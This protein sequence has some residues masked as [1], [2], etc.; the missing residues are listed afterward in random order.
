V[1]GLLYAPGDGAALAAAVD[2][3][4]SDRALRERLR[5]A[6]VR[7]VQERSWQAVNEQLIGHYRAVIAERVELLVS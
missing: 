7:S 2:R 4:V 3:L 5:A 1:T 6:A